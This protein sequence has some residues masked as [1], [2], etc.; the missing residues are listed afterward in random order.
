VVVRRRAVLQC[1]VLQ[2]AVMMRG[3]GSSAEHGALIDNAAFSGGAVQPARCMTRVEGNVLS[4]V[5]CPMI[6]FLYLP[7]QVSITPSLPRSHNARGAAVS[8]QWLAVR[9]VAQVHMCAPASNADR[10]VG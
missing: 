1:A 6:A 2:R 10:R 9:P 4:P 3:R 7:V 8:A 5:R